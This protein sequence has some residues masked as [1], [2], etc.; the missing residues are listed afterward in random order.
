MPY[1]PWNTDHSGELMAS[2]ITG[3]IK[4]LM[5]GYE[6]GQEEKKRLLQGAKAAEAMVKTFPEVLQ[7]LGMDE[8]DF[9]A[10]GANEK[11]GTAAGAI[12]G[13]VE[14]Q[15]SQTEG[16][17]RD[18]LRSGIQ[19]DQ[20]V[21]DYHR[22]QIGKLAADQER[23]AAEEK[24]GKAAGEAERN[25]WVKPDAAPGMTQALGP[26][27]GPMI[28]TMMNQ[29][30]DD[31]TDRMT[32]AFNTPGLEGKSALEL[33]KVLRGYQPKPEKSYSNRML[34][35]L[36]A[37]GKP[38]PRG[39]INPNTGYSSFA[40][41][42]K[43]SKKAVLSPKWLTGSDQEF[44]EGIQEVEDS[45][46]Q[47]DLAKKRAAILHASGKLTPKDEAYLA[48]W[49]GPE[50]MQQLKAKAKATLDA[51]KGLKGPEGPK[52]SAPVKLGR[53]DFDQWLKR[54]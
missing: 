7:S 46:Q 45:D 49:A 22:A 36:D 41:D 31:Y 38:I 24:A 15:K 37:E 2:G 19:S 26:D 8:H 52:T 17:Q 43:A 53:D 32:R 12:H 11:I 3:G 39:L 5:A 10:L 35:M 47:M 48:M 34:P 29:Q 27:L 1:G 6:R 13:W 50:Y 44:S 42:P 51:Q 54:K 21:Q 14:K 25:F 30:P 9:S 18:R 40:P 16:L 4:D 33:G 20:A 28:G 23:I